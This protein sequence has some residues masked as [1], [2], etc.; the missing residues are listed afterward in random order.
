MSS[1]RIIGIV[2]MVGSAGLFW[3]GWQAHQSL[4]VSVGRAL[5]SGPSEQTLFLFGS[6]GLFGLIGLVLALRP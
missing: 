6:A 2:L 5:G 3:Q 1:N 4:G